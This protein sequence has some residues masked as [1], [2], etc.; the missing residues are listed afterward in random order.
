M[1]Q[2][3]STVVWKTHW[4][5][6]VNIWL[7]LLLPRCAQPVSLVLLYYVDS[8]YTWH[9]YFSRKTLLLYQTVHKHFTVLFLLHQLPPWKLDFIQKWFKWTWLKRLKMGQ[10]VHITS[11]FSWIKKDDFECFIYCNDIYF[12]WT[13]SVKNKQ[14]NKTILTYS[15]SAVCTCVVNVERL[16]EIKHN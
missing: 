14:T 9:T 10:C 1:N 4:Q 8:F 6:S 12:I 11:P 7:Q 16:L 3:S 5:L 2:I 13:Y 15:L